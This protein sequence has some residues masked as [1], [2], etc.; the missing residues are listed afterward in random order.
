MLAERQAKPRSVHKGELIQP[1]SVRILES[2]GLIGPLA[3]RGTQTIRSL[4]C[5]TPGAELVDLDFGLLDGPYDYG[6]V[7]SYKDFREVVAGQLGENVRYLPGTTVGALRRDRSDRVTGAVLR[8]GAGTREVTAALTVACD[9]RVSRLREA[10]AIQVP[11]RRY[12]H[13]LV[14]FDLAD[15][16]GLGERVVLYLTGNGLRLLFQLPGNRARLYVQIPAHQFREVGRARLDEWACG[17][18]REVRPWNGSPGRCGRVLAACRCCL[19]G[20]ITHPAGRSLAWS[21]SATRRT[22]CTRWSGRA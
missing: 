20:G 10:A 11:M 8:T 21:C 17:L 4:S 19:P 3:R 9:G 1:G 16:T 14:G 12:D 22:V 5:R 6:L 2:A 13:E 18:L 7:N 15:V